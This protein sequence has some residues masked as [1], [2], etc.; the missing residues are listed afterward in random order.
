VTDIKDKDLNPDLK[1]Y[2][3]NTNRIQILNIDP[4]VIVMTRTIQ[5]EE[6]IDPEEGERLLHSRMWV[7]G[8]PFHFIVD[9][10]S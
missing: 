2:S 10:G 3:E 7:K 6:P 4:T 9:I 1:Y 8:T 5:P